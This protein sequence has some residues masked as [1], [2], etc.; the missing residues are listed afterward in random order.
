MRFYHSWRC[1]S[2][3]GTVRTRRPFSSL[4]G[5]RHLTSFDIS[6]GE[7]VSSETSQI[8]GVS[9]MPY[10]PAKVRS[11]RPSALND[12]PPPLKRYSTLPLDRSHIWTRPSRWVDATKAPSGLKAASRTKLLGS[13]S[14]RSSAP[15]LLSQ[16]LTLLSAPALSAR[17]PSGLNRAT[18]TIPCECLL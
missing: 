6:S 3:S 5:T 1:T 16:I 14:V 7:R 11:R 13:F 4:K 15:V 9:D 8:L 12:A 10:M 17:A 2:H 18:S